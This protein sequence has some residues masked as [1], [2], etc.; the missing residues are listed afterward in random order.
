MMDILQNGHW[1]L[2]GSKSRM[3]LDAGSC[4][5]FQPLAGPS[6]RP[7]TGPGVTHRPVPPFDLGQL[8]PELP[9]RLAEAPVANVALKLVEEFLGHHSPVPERALSAPTSDGRLHVAQ[10]PRPSLHRAGGCSILPRRI[11]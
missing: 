4:L 3:V 8:V 7:P 10:H 1:F 11:G 9:A 2:V 5:T 6:L